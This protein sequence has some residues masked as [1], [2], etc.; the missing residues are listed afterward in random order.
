MQI[1]FI[2]DTHGKHDQI[3]VPQGDILIHAGDI[4]STGTREE[5]EA[6][7]EWFAGQPHPQK[8]FVG[9]NHDFYLEEKDETFRATV[10]PGCTYLY[11]DSVKVAGIKMWGSPLTPWFMDWAFNIDRGDPIRSYWDG[12][13]ADTE[14]LITHGPPYGILDRTFFGAAVGCEELLEVVHAIRPRV[15]VF[16]HIHEAYGQFEKDGTLYINASVLDKRYHIAH[17]PVVVN[18]NTLNE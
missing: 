12:I 18:W 6:F 3:A 17:K 14:L 1:V 13:P 15:H 16:G 9:G 8:V 4:C 2:S 5:A 10:P 11:N 7:L